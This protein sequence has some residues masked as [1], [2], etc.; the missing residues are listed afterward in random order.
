M[1]ARKCKGE[2]QKQ[3]GELGQ[4][5]AWKLMTNSLLWVVL[6]SSKCAK[7]NVISYARKC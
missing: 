1:H 4:I 3:K 7:N 2:P 5:N 6:V